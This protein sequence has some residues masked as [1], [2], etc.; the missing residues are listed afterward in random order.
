MK[1]LLK[2][3]AATTLITVLSYGNSYGQKIY[4]NT[5]LTIA[6]SSKSHT[7]DEKTAKTGSMVTN[8]LIAAK[9]ATSF[10]AASNQQWTD[11][12]KVFWVSFLNNGCKAR[13]SFNTKGKMNYLITDCAME[14]LP[15]PFRKTI[16]RKFALYTL[17]HAIKIN[18]YDAVAYQVV[19]EN[20]STYI[21]LKFT[22]EG[23]EEVQKIIKTFN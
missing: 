19:L 9:F 17:Y 2:A 1:D 21:T 18:A 14:Q 23:V 4:D 11:N 13:A 15:E 20:T 6:Y 8:P 10:P 7:T 16:N 3:I 12:D 5:S 22:S